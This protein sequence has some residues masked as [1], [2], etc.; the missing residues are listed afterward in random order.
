MEWD[1][2]QNSGWI[3][4]EAFRGDRF[5]QRKAAGPEL[6]APDD[7]ASFSFEWSAQLRPAFI[8]AS[9]YD[10]LLLAQRLLSHPGARAIVLTEK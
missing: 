1:A 10:E 6:S 5:S 8:P 2:P 7:K 4:L 3:R 9:D